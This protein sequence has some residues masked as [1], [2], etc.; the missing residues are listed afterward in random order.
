MIPKL[1]QAIDDRRDKLKPARSY[2][3]DRSQYELD[4]DGYLGVL[5]VEH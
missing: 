5:L 1:A 3:L 4:G 2:E